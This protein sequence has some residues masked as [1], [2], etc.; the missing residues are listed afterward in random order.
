MRELCCGKTVRIDTISRQIIFPARSSSGA[1]LDQGDEL[2][3]AA[4]AEIKSK[5]DQY[6]ALVTLP[7]QPNGRFFREAAKGLWTVFSELFPFAPPSVIRSRSIHSC[8]EVTSFLHLGSIFHHDEDIRNEGF[9][10]F[11]YMNWILC[12][13]GSVRIGFGESKLNI[14][15]QLLMS[16]MHSI[17]CPDR[18]IFER[19]SCLWQTH[20]CWVRHKDW[21]TLCTEMEVGHQDD[22][23]GSVI[24]Q[25]SVSRLSGKELYDFWHRWFKNEYKKRVLLVMGILDSQ[26]SGFC[27]PATRTE[28]QM[29][30]HLNFPLP[31]NV[32]SKAVA[33]ILVAEA[34]EPCPDQL[35]HAWPPEAWA[36]K[37][38]QLASSLLPNEKPK[39]IG[40]ML[41]ELLKPHLR[42]ENDPQVVERRTTQFTLYILLEHLHGSWITDCNTLSDNAWKPRSQSKDSRLNWRQGFS[43]TR[44]SSDPGP[45]D[46]LSANFEIRDNGQES[47]RTEQSASIASTSDSGSSLLCSSSA[48]P[49]RSFWAESVSSGKGGTPCEREPGKVGNHLLLHGTWKDKFCLMVR[50]HSVSLELSVPMKALVT[51]VEGGLDTDK[52]SEEKERTRQELVEWSKTAEARRA[53]LHCGCILALFEYQMRDDGPTRSKA[54]PHV[55]HAFFSSVL[56]LVALVKIRK[57]HQT[58][59]IGNHQDEGRAYMIPCLSHLNLESLWSRDGINDHGLQVWDDVGLAGVSVSERDL[60]VGKGDWVK[61]DFFYMQCSKSSFSD[62]SLLRHWILHGSIR[63]LWCF[64]D[65]YIQLLEKSLMDMGF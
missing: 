24:T 14:A 7:R 26:H 3:R 22:D 50:W 13:Q 30:K 39:M 48:S 32:E 43:L 38:A 54:V 56:V 64:A 18:Y 15:K 63:F 12:F 42:F 46:D 36:E 20:S 27:H 5:F 8:E 59:D 53:S 55:S 57:T 6:L 10:V 25:D 40:E 23:R 60:G 9:D 51:F 2:A 45:T 21:R 35:F 11:R 1:E 44:A 19:V 29:E 58:A 49:Q 31:M 28:A 17:M 62:G 61:D 47:D 65:E 4:V 16:I 52:S 33:Q 34:T 41:E 37:V